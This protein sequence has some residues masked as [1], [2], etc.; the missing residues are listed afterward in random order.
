MVAR[1]GMAANRDL[2]VAAVTPGVGDGIVVRQGVSPNGDGSN[3]FLMIEGITNYPDSKL[4][5]MNRNGMLVYEAKGYDNSAR[6]F[7]GHS[8]K[9]GSMPPPGTYF[10]SLTYKVKGVIKFKTGFIVL[11]Y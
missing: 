8:N 10:Y 1:A 6:V 11:K 3:D 4:T 2:P 7:D 5:I 9:N